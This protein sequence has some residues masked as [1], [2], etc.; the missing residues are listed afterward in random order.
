V[1]SEVIYEGCFEREEYGKGQIRM[2]SNSSQTL[3]QQARGPVVEG[4]VCLLTHYRA[5]R[6]SSIWLSS[7]HMFL[8]VFAVPPQV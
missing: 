6:S 3:A 2:P 5:A 8:F 7:C 1:E 4:R